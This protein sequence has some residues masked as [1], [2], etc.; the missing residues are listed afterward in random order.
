M[1]NIKVS[2]IIPVYNSQQYLKQCLDNVVN[3]TLRDIEII[4]VNDGST[5]NSLLIIQ[6][7]ANKYKNIKVINKQNEGCYKARNVG[8]ETS[9]GEYISFLDS[10][11]YIETTIYEKLYLKAKQTDADIVSSNYY[12]LQDNKL[13]LVDFSSSAALLEK[14]NNSLAGAENILLDAIIWS[15]IFKRQMLVEKSI[16]FHSDIYM[17]DDAFF[18]IVTMLNSKEIIYI[19]DVLYTYRISRKDSITSSYNERN[20]DC[21]K[22]A[23][24]IM[25]YAIANNM[26]HFMPQIVAFVLRLNIVG[27]NR[28]GK[29]Y[30][31]QYFEQMCKFV[32]DYC[33][34]SKTNIA[35]IKKPLYLYH[36]F[37]FKAVIYKNKF[38]LD[39]LIK[40]REIMLNLKKI[41]Q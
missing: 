36:W 5:D 37:G 33:I 2:V 12:I 20:F 6:E 31:K 23:K 26:E 15:R 25:D 30:K 9:T 35:F 24:K 8:L 7:Y 32:E 22:V 41:L 1:N 28:V 27:Y 29:T 4:I 38:F 40:V 14:S 11:D 34:T 18:H 39:L 19:P 3:Q 16:K 13:K 17:A 10:D 21:I